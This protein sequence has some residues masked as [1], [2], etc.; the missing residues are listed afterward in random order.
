[1]QA[2]FATHP[3]GYH[4]KEYALRSWF[5]EG[6]KP[7]LAC[8]QHPG[9]SCPANVDY[10]LYGRG[11]GPFLSYGSNPPA[12]ATFEFGRAAP[13]VWN[14]LWNRQP[15]GVTQGP[16]YDFVFIVR[17]GIGIQP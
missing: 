15:L 2:F 7:Q 16:Y 5:D 9:T 10:S 12:N 11:L 14:W 13:R 3:T 8:Q 17:D 1:M 4:Q 6:Y